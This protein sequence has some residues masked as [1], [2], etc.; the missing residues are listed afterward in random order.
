VTVPWDTLLL[1]VLLYIVVPVIAAQIVR[2]AVLARGGQSALDRL[3]ARS[4][5]YRSSRCWRRWSCCSAFRVRR[6]WRSRW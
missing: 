6:S 3:L 5:R 1:S 2:R 4:A